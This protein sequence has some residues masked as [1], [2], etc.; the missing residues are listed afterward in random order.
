MFYVNG[1]MLGTVSTRCS[2]VLQVQGC[3]PWIAGREVILMIATASD[4]HHCGT[5]TLGAMQ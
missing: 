3:Q 2:S 4:K 5:S 1:L